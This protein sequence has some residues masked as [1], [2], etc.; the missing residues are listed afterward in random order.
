LGKEGRV[1][2]GL[3][4]GWEKR[5]G[6]RVGKEVREGRLSVGQSREA[7]GCQTGRIKD[8]KRLTVGKR[9]TGYKSISL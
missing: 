2:C 4:A 5:E 7:K 9:G 3:R 8:G 6:S 1:K